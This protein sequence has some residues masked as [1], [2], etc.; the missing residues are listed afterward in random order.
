MEINIKMHIVKYWQRIPTFSNDNI[1]RQAYMENIEL[2]K[3][4]KRTWST[5]IRTTL[6][7][8]GWG[9]AWHLNSNML[10][11]EQFRQGLTDQLNQRIHNTLFDDNVKIGTANKL[12]TYR[13]HTTNYTTIVAGFRAGFVKSSLTTC[14]IL[15]FSAI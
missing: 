3:Y 5:C 12:L 2:N 13:E 9:N 11:I 8:N 6:E 4:N 7:S 10:N 14:E 1:L 15:S